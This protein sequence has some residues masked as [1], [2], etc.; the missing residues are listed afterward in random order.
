MRSSPEESRGEKNASD[1]VVDVSAVVLWLSSSVVV[2]D[3][4]GLRRRRRSGVSLLLSVA[5]DRVLISS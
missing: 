3:L 4:D 2:D 5:N 1:E